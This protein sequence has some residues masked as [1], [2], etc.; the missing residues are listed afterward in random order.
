MNQLT[1]PYARGS[2]TSKAAAKSVSHTAASSLRSKC[3]SFI[4]SMGGATCDEIEV[5]FRMRHQ[6]ASAR[7]RELAQ[8]D[9]IKDSGFNRLTRSGRSATVWAVKAGA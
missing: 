1:L 2:A 5:A 9:L 6:T 3:L 7:I 4:K 8:R